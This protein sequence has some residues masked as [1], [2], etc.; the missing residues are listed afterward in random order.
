LGRSKKGRSGQVRRVVPGRLF[1]IEVPLPNEPGASESYAVKL[2]N[3][4]VF[5]SGDLSPY[6]G[7]SFSELG[8]RQGAIV[9]VVDPEKPGDPITV[10]VEPDG[11]S[12]QFRFFR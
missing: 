8:I 11:S 2:D 5:R 3:V 1:Y 7:E 12:D 4:L 9:L 6:R 10:V